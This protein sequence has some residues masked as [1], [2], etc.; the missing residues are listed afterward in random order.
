MRRTFFTLAFCECCHRLLFHGFR[1][2]TCGFRFHQ[3]CLSQVPATC[4][5]LV[6]GT[7]PPPVSINRSG[8]KLVSHSGHS[9]S[10]NHSSTTITTSKRTTNCDATN[11]PRLPDA[12]DS[13]D[14]SESFDN[15]NSNHNQPLPQSLSTPLFTTNLVNDNKHHYDRL[16]SPVKKAARFHSPT[17]T[18]D[19][20]YKSKFTFFV[21]NEPSSP[22]DTSLR[23]LF[24]TYHHLKR[25][26]FDVYRR[27]NQF[28]I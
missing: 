16:L 15:N 7:N 3:R 25:R 22:V 1:C 10:N 11:N 20:D 17:L 5:P 18:P 26:S 13:V 2:Q 9:P 8:H 4:Q 27:R 6:V 28:S 19:D 24:D 21:K 14:P 12:V 23:P